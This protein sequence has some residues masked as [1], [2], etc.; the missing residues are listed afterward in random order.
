MDIAAVLTDILVVLVAAKVAAELAERLGVPAVVGEI[1]AGVIIGPSALGLV[2][3]HDEVLRTLGEIGVILL[4]LEVG[5]EMDLVELGKVGRASLL[6]AIAGVVTPM[7]LGFG[8]MELFHDGDFKTSLFVG[9]ALTATSVGITARVFGDLRALATTEARIVL[10]AAVADDVMGLVVLTVVV[11][12]VTEGSVSVASVGVI[13]AVAVAF[14]VVGGLGGLRLSGP[15]FGLVH[16]VSRSTGTMVALALAFTLAFARI[17]EAAKLAPIVGAFVAGIAL[18]RSDQ[19]ER[20][21]RELT[22][23]GHLF[24][25]VFFLQIGIDAELA[26]FGR[27]EV[28]GTAAILLVVAVIGKMVSPIGALGSRG[29]KLLIGLGMLP[30]GEVGLIFATIGLTTGVL[31][32]AIYAALLLVVLVT[33]LATPQLLKVRYSRLRSSTA[34]A[35]SPADPEPP[36]GWLRA[37]GEVQLAARP[38]EAIALE[39]ALQSAVLVGRRDP[40]EALAT[41]LASVPRSAFAW[42]REAL[43]D[44][45]DVIE[46]GNAR[47]WRFL[48]TTGVL[49][50]ALPEVSDAFRRRR[51]DSLSVDLLEA[52]RTP[53]LA[54]LRQINGGDPV[55]VE[56]ARLLK[57]E[58]L[59]LALYLVDVLEA[60]PQRAT[61]ARKIVARLGL[62]VEA[63]DAVVDL[64]EDAPLLWGAALRA[65][66]F[67]EEAVV[68]LA[69]HLE[70]G[71]RARALY[72]VSALGGADRPGWA[73]T[74]LKELYRLIQEVLAGDLFGQ[75]GSGDLLD[76]RRT[77]A[78]ALLGDAA[79]RQRVVRAPRSYVARREP[80]VLA[81]QAALFV[82]TLP[83]NGARV[84]VLAASA[85]DEWWV[86]VAAR[87]RRGLLATVTE[88]LSA[89]ALD[90][91]EA[92]VATWPDEMALESFLVRASRAPDATELERQVISAFDD[93]LDT[94]PLAGAEVMFDNTCSP[95]H[96]VCE[97]IAPDQAGLLHVIAAA[98]AAAGV[99]VVAATVVVHDGIADDRFEVVDARGNKLDEAAFEVFRRYLSQGVRSKRRRF[100]R[101]RFATAA[102]S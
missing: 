71:E 35:T 55:A 39:L 23:V 90:V 91:I 20:I 41:W 72:V 93:L 101:Q 32:K 3:Q 81:R 27:T 79:A 87:D 68:Q 74:R 60:V 50:G 33:T 47:S 75:G 56:A 85:P 28:L 67:A 98:F 5:M 29:D 13:V 97:V 34:D 49:D 48:D 54:R 66:G 17:A 80:G 10:G 84:Q 65:G 86:D 30:R 21:R 8:A 42:R 22:P 36:G 40:G 77:A 78:I 18:T 43:D 14:L 51:N 46:R 83:S 76:L 4:L 7:L 2:G 11:R 52:Y 38:P 69:S 64:V 92:V 62:G 53:S 6:V 61:T 88:V 94:G 58:V 57:P 100:G 25:P 63:E 82:P 96:T 70:T 59:L 31:D 89:E 15:L 19:S 26:A 73:Q 95:W 44:L 102:A 24:I 12:I 9:A 45:L 37:D 99:D 16:R 1:V